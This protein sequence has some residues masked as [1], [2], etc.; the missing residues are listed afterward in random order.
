MPE[1][2][3]VAK[4]PEI[5]KNYPNT[6]TFTK[7]NGERLL[8]KLRG[9]IPIMISRPSIVGASMAEPAPGWIDSLA[10]AAS[11][12][13][14]L[15]TG[16]VNHMLGDP[17]AHIDIIP[18]DYLCNS[19]LVGTAYLAKKD[20]FTVMHAASTH[21]HPTTVFSFFSGCV[22]YAKTQPFEN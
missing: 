14:G 20:K 22:E 11:F 3:L 17:K 7:S 8:K 2:E 10:A 4:T 18:V 13:H 5:I 15:A 12:V 21:R 16:I 19:I 1:E 6:Y 9:H